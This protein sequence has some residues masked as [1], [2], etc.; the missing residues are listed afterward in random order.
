M[1]MYGSNLESIFEKYNQRFESKTI[2]QLGL[3]MLEIFE[4]IHESGYIY[5][6][7]KLDNI[8]IGDQFDSI[9]SLS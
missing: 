4:K 2:F 8:V 5:N 6:D 9:Q 7:L 1:P 3:Q